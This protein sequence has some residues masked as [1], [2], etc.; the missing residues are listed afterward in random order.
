LA[1]GLSVCITFFKLV[2]KLHNTIVNQE[3]VFKENSCMRIPAIS[4]SWGS[5]WLCY[6]YELDN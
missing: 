3:F 6:P 4:D 2:T 1:I 5:I